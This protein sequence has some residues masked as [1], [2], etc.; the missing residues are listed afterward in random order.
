M[1]GYSDRTVH[2]LAYA[3]KQFARDESRPAALLARPASLALLLARYQCDE[4]TVVAA[5]LHEVLTQSPA[6]E[7][8]ELSRRIGEKFGPVVLAV[9]LEAQEP[10]PPRE[11]GMRRTW[12][13]ERVDL[14]SHLLNLEPR[15]LSIRAAEEILACGSVVSDLRRLGREYLPTI[16]SA[17]GEQ[18]LWWF[19]AV[20]ETL[21]RHDEWPRREMVTELRLL[22]AELAAELG[23]T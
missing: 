14:L 9:A 20:G 19:R 22:T 13:T 23:G 16:T 4:V 6:A 7:R 21:D 12:E 15:T 18:L 8:A 10:D 2:A 3:A 11:R 5:V 1:S 17:T